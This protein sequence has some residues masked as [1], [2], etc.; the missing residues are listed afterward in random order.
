ML[1]WDDYIAGASLEE[2]LSALARHGERAKVVAGATDLYTWAREGR[3]GDV[4]FDALVDVT[5]IPQ[6][7]GVRMEQGRLWIGANTTIAE[8]VRNPLLLGHAPVLRRCAVWFADDQIREQATIGG[9]IVNASPAGDAMPPL[10]TQDAKVTLWRLEA[11]QP[12]S[13]T[14]PLTEFI[15]G[16]G[17]T[18]LAPGEL[19]GHIDVEPAGEYGTAFEKVGHRR[20]LVISTACLAVLARLDASRTRF[21]DLRIAIGAVGPVPERLTEVERLLAGRPVGA[22]LIADA[23]QMAEHHVRSRSRKEYRRE[24]LV[25]FVERGIVNALR[26]CGVALGRDAGNLEVSH[27]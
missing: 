24:V 17:K 26:E 19:L 23:A 3:A 25:N 15:T 12:A 6:L 21:H 22:E 11:G 1:I 7:S 4:H 13:R 9:N 8:F 2:T 27:A 14:M 18:Q 20:S 16:P 5:K 10:L